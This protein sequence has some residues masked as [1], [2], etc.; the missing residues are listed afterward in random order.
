[1]LS[2]LRSA[3]AQLRLLRGAAPSA[4]AAP[5]ENPIAEQRRREVEEKLALERAEK[6]KLLAAVCRMQRC[7]CPNQPP[8]Y[9][10]GD[11]QMAGP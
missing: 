1:M 6:A 4:A 11:A 2:V 9:C 5:A 7:I 3:Q 8:V 10:V